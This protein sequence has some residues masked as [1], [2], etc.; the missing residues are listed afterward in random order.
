MKY[1]VV[2]VSTLLL[3][4]SSYAKDTDE[5]DAH[6]VK[7]VKKSKKKKR[8]KIKH[9]LT[10]TID[11]SSAY[12]SNIFLTPSSAYVDYSTGTYEGNGLVIPKSSSGMFSDYMLD[13][14]YNKKYRKGVYFLANYHLK[15]AHYYDAALN[16][17][18]HHIQKLSVGALYKFV[19]TNKRHYSVT[20][21][22]FIGSD[23]NTYY[24]RDHGENKLTVSAIDISNRNQH[25][26]QGVETK[27]ILENRKWLNQTSFLFEDLDY[28]KPN[29]WSELDHS[30]YFL[31]HTVAYRFSKKYR[32]EMGFKY[33]KRDFIFRGSYKYTTKPVFV[34]TTTDPNANRVYTYF[35]TFFKE[36]V[37]FSSK[38]KAS[39]TYTNIQRTDAYA[40]YNDSQTNEVLAHFYYKKS[41]KRKIHVK[42]LYSH[43]SFPVAMAFDRNP[44]LGTPSKGSKFYTK[45]KIQVDYIYKKSKKLEYTSYVKLMQYDSSDDRYVYDRTIAGISAH[46]SF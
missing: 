17:A 43:I 42:A 26:Y 19:N 46:Y 30:Y 20:A 4:T 28:E 13:L 15:G 3:V 21:K 5:N 35:D 23:H 39:F 37:K 1:L 22:A 9:G 32:S 6:V 10:T 45:K 38:L 2:G 11:V 29:D 24:D 41:K 8:K 16:N 12:D 44:T 34:S 25:K 36:D 7:K 18:N 31:K 27:L 33:S 40:G 14:D